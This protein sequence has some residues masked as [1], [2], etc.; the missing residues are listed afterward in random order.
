MGES[1]DC[2]FPVSYCKASLI[3]R[4]NFHGVGRRVGGE[5]DSEAGVGG[6]V[7]D[8]IE[9]AAVPDTVSQS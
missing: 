8:Q 4:F 5:S 7:Q 1:R 9:S 3:P 6:R 2:T